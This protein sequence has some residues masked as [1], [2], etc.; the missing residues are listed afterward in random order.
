MDYILSVCFKLWN[1]FLQDVSLPTD[2]HCKC[3]SC[4]SVCFLCSWVVT[5]Y[6]FTETFHVLRDLKTALRILIGKLWW[7]FRAKKIKKQSV[8]SLSLW[9]SNCPITGRIQ[10]L[11]ECVRA[12]VRAYVCVFRGLRGFPIWSNFHTYSKQADRHIWANSVDQDQTP[13]TQHF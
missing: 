1:V 7:F 9:S 4:M 8:F 10:G 3:W 11:K 6:Y 2:G 5:L 13:L 12:C